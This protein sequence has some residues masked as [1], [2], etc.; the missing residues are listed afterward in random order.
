M[1]SDLAAHQ[2]TLCQA[3]MNWSQTSQ[4]VR[5]LHLP[6]KIRLFPIPNLPHTAVMLQLQH[7]YATTSNQMKSTGKLAAVP[8]SASPPLLQPCPAY[9]HFINSASRPLSPHSAP[10]AV[11]AR[12]SR[13]R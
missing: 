10:P 6:S 12:P 3:I 1:E 9:E 8:I 2:L 11:H 5:Q 13:E 7:T 4:K